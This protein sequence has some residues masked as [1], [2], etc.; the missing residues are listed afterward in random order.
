MRRSVSFDRAASFYDRTRAMSPAV[1]EEITDAILA[2]L[3]RAGADRLLEVGVGTGRIARPLIARGLPVTGVD[4]APAMMAQLVAQLTPQHRR[5]N[6]I[7]ADATR[8]PFR[9]AAF[10]AVITVHVLHLVSS[11][12][13]AITEARRVLAP[14]GVFLHKTQRDPEPLKDS[15]DW[16]DN[17]LGEGGHPPIR[18][19]TFRQQREI[20][21]ATGATLESFD[22]A[23]ETLAYSPD[24][25][26]DLA[27]RRVHSWTW[28]VA[29]DT[30]A[31]L[32]PAY[33]AWFR[34]RYTS[35]IVE[36]ITHELEVWRWPGG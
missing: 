7:L 19:L 36:E 1:S 25:V 30:F 27:R 10:P 21:R 2:Q 11:I 24:D 5:P 12:H 34:A 32:F 29:E 15:S 3:S 22:V 6:L 8:L 31:Q 26:L 18:R 4:I 33:E 9:D 20:I 14:G 23:R 35:E 28:Q 17:A 16:W 13:D